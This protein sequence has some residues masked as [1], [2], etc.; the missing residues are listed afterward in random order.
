MRVPM[1]MVDELGHKI[2][3]PE[4]WSFCWSRYGTLVA[5]V[6]AV[7]NSSITGQTDFQP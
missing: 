2:A 4:A 5:L 7:L 1:E 3:G 6:L